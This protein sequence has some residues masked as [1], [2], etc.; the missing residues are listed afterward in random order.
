M[1]S[2]KQTDGSI[3]PSGGW[4]DPAVDTAEAMMTMDAFGINFDDSEWSTGDKNVSE[5]MNLPL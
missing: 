2:N 5:Y 3:Y 1:K 4:D